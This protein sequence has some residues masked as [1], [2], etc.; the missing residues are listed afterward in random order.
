LYLFNIVEVGYMIKEHVNRWIEENE[1]HLCGVSD[2]IWEYAELGL[3]EFKSSSLLANELETNGFKVTHGAAGMPTA[4]VATYGEGKPI[5]GI[6]GEYDA[7]SGL[8]QE[9]IPEQKP[10]VE[11]APGHGCGHNIHGTSGMGAAVAVSKALEAEQIEGTV[12]FF[13]CPAEETVVGKVFMVRDGVFRGVDALF[14]HHPGTMNSA[15][16]RS[17]NALNSVKFEFFG[18]ASHAGGSPHSGRSAL[19]AVELM[20]VGVNFMREHVVQEARIHYVIENGGGAPNVVPAYARSWYFVRAPERRQV[21]QIYKWTLKIAEGAALMTETT[22]DYSLLTGCYNLLP[23]ESMADLVVENMKAIGAPTYTKE[24]TN[25]AKAIQETLSPQNI[26]NELKR[27]KRCNW[28]SLQ[29]VVIDRSIPEPWGKG[30]VMGGSTDVGDVSWR[31]PTI[32]FNTSTWVLGM[33]GHSWQIVAMGKSGIAHKSLLFATKTIAYCVLD[34]LTKPSLLKKMKEEFNEEKQGHKYISPL[35]PDQK[36][37]FN[38]FP[39]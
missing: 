19:D 14:S 15:R 6:M 29:D 37:P 10:I 21:E 3:Q 11:G 23:V 34:T 18:V 16:L 7:L 28:Q 26:V 32:E 1:S 5:I 24:E 13:G 4:I 36:L 2:T 35:T 30:E 17:S 12:K 27:S 38:Q 22:H 39:S 31:A 33:P 25:F 20:N 9:P 8:S